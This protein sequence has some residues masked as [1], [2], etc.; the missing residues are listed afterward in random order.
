MRGRGFQ[1][2]A[3]AVVV[4]VASTLAIAAMAPA[5]RKGWEV[6]FSSIQARTD[7]QGRGHIRGFIFVSV[8][9]HPKEACLPHRPVRLFEVLPG[10]DKLL[11]SGRTNRNWQYHFSFPGGHAGRNYALKLLR[12]VVRKDG[13]HLHFCVAQTATFDFPS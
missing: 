5:H 12:K 10:P 1:R 11:D 6:N 13:R 2:A 7:Q 3:V 4:L 8:E 9:P